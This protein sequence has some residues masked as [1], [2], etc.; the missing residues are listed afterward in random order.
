MYVA[1][2]F[3]IQSQELDLQRALNT[4]QTSHYLFKQEKNVPVHFFKNS[5]IEI[6]FT[7]YSSL[8]PS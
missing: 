6:Q 5:F 2:T 4:P 8:I 7:Y 3:E 1:L